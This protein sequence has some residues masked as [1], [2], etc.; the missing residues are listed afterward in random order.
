MTSA[1]AKC[2]ELA[3]G[4]TGVLMLSG[5]GQRTDTAVTWGHV[6]RV[7]AQ[8]DECRGGQYCGAMLTEITWG[9]CVCAGT[10]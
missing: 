1:E 2:T 9:V 10:G 4:A 8:D 3:Y 7:C 6:G 5:E